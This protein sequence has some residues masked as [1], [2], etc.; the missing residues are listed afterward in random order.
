MLS[1][2]AAMNGYLQNFKPSVL[3]GKPQ[4]IVAIFAVCAETEE[5][6]NRVASSLDLSA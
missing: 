6:A 4:S 1:W 2:I 3:G 5:E